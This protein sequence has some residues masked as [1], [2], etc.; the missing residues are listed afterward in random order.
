MTVLVASRRV[1]FRVDRQR[2]IGAVF[3]AL[4]LLDVVG[5]GLGA[6]AGDA[7]FGLSLAGASVH[8]PDLVLPARWTAD[9]AGVLSIALG[10]TQ[11]TRSLGRA[12][13]RSAVTAVSVLFVLAFL[14]W[15]DAA[16]TMSLVGLLQGTVSRSIPLVLGALAGCLC[17]RSGVINI[18]IEGQLLVGAFAAAVAASAA[19][20]LWLGVV[21]GSLAGGLIGA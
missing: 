18:A 5:F 15:A 10:A 6:H 2:A 19:G 3:V 9:V 17:E 21:T 7:H 12:A 14:C 1:S 20:T 16:K 13:K 8:V 11:M 4:G